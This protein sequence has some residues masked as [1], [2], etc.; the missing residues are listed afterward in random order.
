M[1]DVTPG[2]DGPENLR[3]L[4]KSELKVG[5]GPC[6]QTTE[7]LPLGHTV[8]FSTV[9]AAVKIFGSL[10]T[11]IL[12]ITKCAVRWDD[13]SIVRIVSLPVSKNRSQKL[14]KPFVPETT[15]SACI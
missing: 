2:R 15:E 10:L 8:E 5:I 9:A 12:N 7:F 11:E 6:R 14:I 4:K 1:D 13:V 3:I